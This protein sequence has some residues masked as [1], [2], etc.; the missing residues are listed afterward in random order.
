M[1]LIEDFDKKGNW[2]FKK[3]SFIPIFLYVI[4]GITLFLT[5]Y[6]VIDFTNIYWSIACLA[7][8]LFGLVIRIITVAL[9]PKGTSG[10]N[11]SAGQVA[12]QLN[13]K[14]IYSIVR[15]PLYVGNFLMWL[16]L[17]IYVGVPEFIIFGIF[18]F[19]LYYERIMF[20]EEQFIRNKFGDDFIKWSAKTPAFFPSFKHYQK[21]DLYFSWKSVL[22]REYSG[23]FA[24]FFSF[25]LLNFMKKYFYF[26]EFIPD[27]F[28]IY[29]T[30]GAFVIFILLRS[31]KKYTSVFEIKDRN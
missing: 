8:S 14:G 7:V 29:S 24:T 10:R 9:T 4:A 27:W 12:D 23:F 1:G 19:W 22:K 6:E 28:W 3:R 25:L 31:L 21:T 2:L 30:A 17:I 15:H 18:F 16:G 11:T 26:E 13:T 20:A 5:D